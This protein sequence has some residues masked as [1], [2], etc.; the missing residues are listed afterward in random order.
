MLPDDT[1][2]G[3]AHDS[4][5][6]KV[7]VTYIMLMAFTSVVTGVSLA[8]TGYFRL[9]RFAEFLPFPVLCSVLP[10]I[11]VVFLQIGYKVA[12]GGAPLAAPFTGREILDTSDVGHHI[13]SGTLLVS[14]CYLCLLPCALPASCVFCLACAL[15]LV[16]HIICLVSCAPYVISRL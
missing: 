6:R 16:L 9:L 7:V 12:T 11:G 5:L 14:T 10:S 8:G 13:S 2:P 3:L 1:A 15:C 4:A